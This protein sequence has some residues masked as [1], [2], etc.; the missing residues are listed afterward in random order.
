MQRIIFVKD[1]DGLY[2]RDPKKHTGREAHPAHHP[3]ELTA[4]MPEEL[5]L[6]RSSSTR[7]AAA[8]HVKRVQIVNG[9]SR[10]LTRALAGED[11]GT[12]ITKE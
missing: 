6:D 10:Q 9:S 5:I 11:V 4:N 3:G 8:R 1:E 7:G 12:V 2:D